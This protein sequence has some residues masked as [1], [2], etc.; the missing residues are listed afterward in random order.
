[1]YEERDP[2]VIDQG[3]TNIIL[4]RINMDTVTNYFFLMKQFQLKVQ[5][6]E[7]RDARNG[8]VQ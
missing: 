8:E 5:S 3:E 6:R 7:S 2:D 1:M 4:I